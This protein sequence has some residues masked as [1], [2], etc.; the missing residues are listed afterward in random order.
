MHPASNLG[1]INS[2]ISCVRA[3]KNK[4][5]SDKGCISVGP[6]L[7]SLRIRFPNSVEPGSTKFSTLYPFN[8]NDFTRSRIWV[9]L[10]AA[11]PP[12]NV[13]NR[14]TNLQVKIIQF[15]DQKTTLRFGSFP[16]LTE[17]ILYLSAAKCCKR[18][19]YEL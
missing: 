9:V 14:F 4:K 13:I 12:S 6:Y 11:S 18:R 1:I 2:L 15:F 16:I 3:A 17:F 5:V 8:I 7:T 10:P 19:I